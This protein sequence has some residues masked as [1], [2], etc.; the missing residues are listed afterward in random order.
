MEIMDNTPV[1]TKGVKTIFIH[2]DFVNLV[3]QIAK[4]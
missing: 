4:P 3:D 2:L 1:F